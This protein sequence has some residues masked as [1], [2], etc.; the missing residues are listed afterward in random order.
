MQAATPRAVA[1]RYQSNS[2][3]PLFVRAI[4]SKGIYTAYFPLT[5]AVFGS[6]NPQAAVRAKSYAH[7]D[8]IITDL[9]YGIY[10]EKTRVFMIGK[11]FPAWSFTTQKPPEGTNVFQLL[12]AQTNTVQAQW[13]AVWCACERFVVDRRIKIEYH[14]DPN[15][16]TVI[17][18]V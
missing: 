2:H 18:S 12:D 17:E 6:I 10:D 9:Q 14:I 5:G 13:F 4:H 16:N 8:T 3:A 11:G 15:T 1:P 7:G